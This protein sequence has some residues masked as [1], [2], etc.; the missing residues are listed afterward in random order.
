MLKRET[1]FS[2]NLEYQVSKLLLRLG[3]QMDNDFITFLLMLP[4][5]FGGLPIMCPLE[6]LYRGHP[7]PVTSELVWIKW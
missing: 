1:K 6:L 4:S 5:T 2:L 3:T 7:D